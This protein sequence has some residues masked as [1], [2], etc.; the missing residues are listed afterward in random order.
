MHSMSLI[1]LILPSVVDQLGVWRSESL[2]AAEEILLSGLKAFPDESCI[3][4][5]GCYACVAGRLDAAK[6][7]LSRAME[8]GTHATEIGA[9]RRGPYLYCE[10]G[11]SALVE[12]GLVRTSD[13]RFARYWFIIYS[14]TKV[15]PQTR[16][17][18]M[19]S[20]LRPAFI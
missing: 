1:K 16:F 2:A 10:I 18:K 20:L 9:S 6:D 11:W 17:F 8:L 5:L 4:N 13:L 7:R 14:F 15:C 3:H 12:I 19:R